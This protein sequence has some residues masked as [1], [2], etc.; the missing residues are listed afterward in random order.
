MNVVSS[1]LTKTEW[2]ANAFLNLSKPVKENLQKYK[3][4]AKKASWGRLLTGYVTLVPK[5]LVQ[6]MLNVTL[7]FITPWEWARKKDIDCG[8]Y[9]WLILSNT[10]NLRPPNFID[11]VMSHFEEIIHEDTA[12]LYLN[13]ER[14]FYHAAKKM[15]NIFQSH[16]NFLCPK[17]SNPA[18]TIR[19]VFRN[20][21]TVWEAI[22]LLRY[23]RELDSSQKT[24]ILAAIVAQFSRRTM[25]NFL[26]ANE[27]ARH[28]QV[29][30]IENFVYSFEGNPHEICIL[31]KLHSSSPE[32]KLHPYQHAP[33]IPSQAGLY[34]ELLFFGKRT[35]LLTSGSVTKNYF[36]SVQEKLGLRFSIL[37][38]GSAK[39][40]LPPIRLQGS[41]SSRIEDVL[42][43]PE[44][45]E[46]NFIHFVKVMIKLSRIRGD[47]SFVIR[48]H[49]SLKISSRALASLGSQMPTN[50]KISNRPLGEDFHNSKICI[51][52]S[53]A[54][55]IE[56]TI[57]GVYPIHIDFDNEFALNPFD[58]QIIPGIDLTANSF[59]GLVDL[60]NSVANPKFDSNGQL[61]EKLQE[62]A[63]SYF[64]N[65]LASEFYRYLSRE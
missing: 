49:P 42:F 26:I 19:Q 52:R 62:I 23:Q 8:S 16:K 18:E 15:P 6:V 28:A 33:I 9:K 41:G 47:L 17:T 1:F 10:S 35:L 38:A 4:V 64:S 60:V 27:V 29:L 58:A 37:E 31:L 61:T 51:Y 56:S 55:A 32:L 50:C 54:A 20:I 34:R 65:P 30:A 21:V 46:Q 25:S 36:Q 12:Y 63:A 11:S 39:Y 43:L 24:V 45:D 14:S 5:V 2:S 13:A 3:G 22:Q 7:S 40:Q 48:K 44:G 59:E 53:S 57:F